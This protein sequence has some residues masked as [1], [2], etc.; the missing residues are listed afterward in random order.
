ATCKCTDIAD[1][2]PGDPERARQVLGDASARGFG[3]PWL[4]EF[5]GW[6]YLDLGDCETAIE[7]FERALSID[8]SIESAEEGIRECG[9]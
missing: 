5:I 1:P 4:E 7:H 2:S 8:P 6:T 3:D 9:G